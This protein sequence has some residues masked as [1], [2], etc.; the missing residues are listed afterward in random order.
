MREPDVAAYDTSTPDDGLAAENGRARVNNHIVFNARVSFG[1][2]NEFA[3]R[4]FVKRER[5]ERDALIELDVV[6]YAGRAAYDYARAV[7][8][9]EVRA[10]FRPRMN[11]YPRA[12][13]RVLGH[14]A[15][16]ERDVHAVQHVRQPV[17]HYGIDARVA[18]DNL[19][20]AGGRGVAFIGGL[21]I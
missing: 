1:I 19:V 5:A 3:R 2:A 16:D 21:N 20:K 15:R 14:D 7:V 12:V 8:Y 18:E 4:V 11:I 6:A 10:D 9:E 17:D 13:V